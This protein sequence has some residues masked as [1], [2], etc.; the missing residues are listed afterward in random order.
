MTHRDFCRSFIP[1]ET[2]EKKEA[3]MKA[4]HFSFETSRR[5]GAGKNKR[6]ATRLMKTTKLNY[7]LSDCH[8]HDPPSRRTIK[9]GQHGATGCRMNEQSLVSMYCV[10]FASVDKYFDMDI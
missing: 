6:F 1:A 5:P 10:Y 4:C 7:S 8:R 2:V 9:E 3:F